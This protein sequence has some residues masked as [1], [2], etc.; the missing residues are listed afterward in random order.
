MLYRIFRTWPSG[1][2]KVHASQLCTFLDSGEREDPHALALKEVTKRSKSGCKDV[3]EQ[4]YS[5][6]GSSP[7]EGEQEPRTISRANVSDDQMLGYGPGREPRSPQAPRL[8]NGE[9]VRELAFYDVTLK[10]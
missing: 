10:C 7:H 2:S 1:R 8:W 9:A 5:A 3:R 6:L 4:R